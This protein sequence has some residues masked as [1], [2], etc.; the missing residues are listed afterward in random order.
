MWDRLF[1]W[2]RRFD[3]HIWVH[4]VPN[5]EL[6]VAVTQTKEQCEAILDAAQDIF[7]QIKA[8]REK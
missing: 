2:V 3:L 7:E 4:E 6:V 5:D 1:S 8:L